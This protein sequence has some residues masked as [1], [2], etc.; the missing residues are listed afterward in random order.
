M[1]CL[2]VDEMIEDERVG[3]PQEMQAN[4][5]DLSAVDDAGYGLAPA[6]G[7]IPRANSALQDFVSTTAGDSVA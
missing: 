4:I 5:R 3:I 6:A 1:P 7:V 2:R